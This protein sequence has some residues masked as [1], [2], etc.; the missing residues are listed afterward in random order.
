MQQTCKK[1][2]RDQHF[3]FVVTDQIWRIIPKEFRDKALCIE[4]FIDIMDEQVKPYGSFQMTVSDFR[5]LAIVGECVKGV[6]HNT[7]KSQS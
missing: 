4:C 1:C 5:F 6:L 3:E 2:G 7:P